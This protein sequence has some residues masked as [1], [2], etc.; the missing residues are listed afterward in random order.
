MHAYLLALEVAPMNVGKTYAMLPLHCT[1]VQWFW[2]D[3]DSASLTKQLKPLMKH[4]PPLKLISGEE[5]TYTGTTKQGTIPV[6][7]NIVELTPD[8]KKLHLQIC[9]KLNELKVTYTAPQYVGEGYGP[10]ITHQKGEKL[11]EGMVHTSTAVYL[12]EANA[13][14]YGNDRHICFKIELSP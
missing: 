5:T 13:P 12:I 11:P 9:D 7:V 4:T 8:L 2:L 14:E 6:T 3:L 10:H 1:L